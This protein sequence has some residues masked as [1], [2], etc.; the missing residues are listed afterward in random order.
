M[1]KTSLESW[2][3]KKIGKASTEELKLEALEIYQL[4]KLQ[5]TLDYA[6]KNSRFYSKQLENINIGKISSLKDISKLP[7]TTA[8]DIKQQG[9]LFAC[10]SQ[11]EI[12]RIVTLQT[13]GTTSQPKRIFFTKEDQDL[14]VDFF[15]H[16]MANL[17]EPG[18]KALILMPGKRPGSVGDLLKIGLD[19]LGVESLI[20]GP[21]DHASKVLHIIAEEN[22]NSLVG[23][24]QQVLVLAV[25]Y[26]FYKKKIPISLKSILL[27]TDYVPKAVIDQLKDVW[28]CQVFEHYGMTEMGLGG[29]VACEAFEGYH[30]READ[31][32]FEVVDPITR[33]PIAEGE[34][35]EVVFTTLTRKGMPLIRYLT[36]DISRMLGKPC[37]C[38]SPLKRLDKVL[39]RK[40]ECIEL[41]KGKTLT[42]NQLDELLFSIKGITN[43]SACITKQGC[44]DCLSINVNSIFSMK[45]TLIYKVYNKLQSSTVLGELIQQK[46]LILDINNSFIND[47][48]S[49]GMQK[50]KIKD[51]RD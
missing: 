18:D 43:Y 3:K 42:I 5:E 9:P 36:G 29:G 31:L 24:P 13:S 49:D 45:E 35:G 38:G 33:Q 47:D 25:Y 4:Q 16:G 15:H 2:I 6:K 12:N 1:K 17:V 8:E 34:Y 51:L 44:K 19:R 39:Y 21:V 22:I 37:P 10:V 40:S 48:C 11:D 7:F 32:Y 20:Y 50:R 14:T 26:K 41:E 23:L 30:V 46:E 27:S 28:D